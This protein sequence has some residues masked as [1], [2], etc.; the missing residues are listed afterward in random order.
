MAQNSIYWRGGRN[1]ELLLQYFMEQYII[2]VYDLFISHCKDH[3]SYFF[4]LFELE[5]SSVLFGTAIEVLL[6]SYLKDDNKTLF[7]CFRNSTNGD[8]T[9]ISNALG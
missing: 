5:T 4:V 1:V 6:R 2:I 7:C 3:L 8:H 9:C